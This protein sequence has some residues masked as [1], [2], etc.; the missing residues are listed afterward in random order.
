M[1]RLFKEVKNIKS[2]Q[3]GENTEIFQ[4]GLVENEK[5]FQIDENY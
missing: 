4:S 3:N 1:Q 2:F 5:S